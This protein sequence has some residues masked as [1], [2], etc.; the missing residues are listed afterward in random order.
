MISLLAN[1][2]NKEVEEI[3]QININQN[4][5]E[6]TMEFSADSIYTEGI[7]KCDVIGDN[8]LDGLKDYYGDA[9]D[10]CQSN[11]DYVQFVIESLQR[12]NCDLRIMK[13]FESM[14]AH[15]PLSINK[16]ECIKGSTLL[17]DN[18]EWVML[19]LQHFAVPLLMCTDHV[20]HLLKS[21]LQNSVTSSSVMENFLTGYWKYFQNK[22]KDLLKEC[23][24]SNKEG[25]WTCFLS[26]RLNLCCARRKILNMLD[27][28]WNLYSNGMPFNQSFL[29]DS[30]GLVAYSSILALQLTKSPIKWRSLIHTWFVHYQ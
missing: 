30:V 24:N 6:G 16:E 5:M 22:L 1:G 11:D 23:S 7:M 13:I 3:I 21:N 10:V 20:Q 18:M 19:C 29:Q 28:K 9:V 26:V 8:A 17:L 15:V 25:G 4:D 27:G 12:R 14:L 2:T